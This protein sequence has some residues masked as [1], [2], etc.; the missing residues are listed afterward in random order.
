MRTPVEEQPWY[1]QWKWAT[2]RL[3]AAREAR[4]KEQPG[5]PAWEAAEA[6]YQIALDDYRALAGQIG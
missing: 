1:P 3:I 5:T 2:E 4:D 6:K